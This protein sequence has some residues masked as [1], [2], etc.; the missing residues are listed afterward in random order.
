MS[1]HRVWPTHFI[2]HGDGPWPWLMGSEIHKK[3]LNL[4]QSL[5]TLIPA[6]GEQ[7]RAIIVVSAHWQEPSFTLMTNSQAPIVYDYEG[8]PKHT[9][10][11]E[12]ATPNDP[13]LVKRIATQIINSGIHLKL[14]PDR[15]FDQGAFAPLTVMF[16]NANIPT[17]QISLNTRLDAQEHLRLGRALAPLRAEG[18]LIIGSGMSFHNFNLDADKTLRF[19]A[20]FDDWLQRCLEYAPA[21][22][23]QR[24]CDWRCA[25]SAILA[26]PTPEHFLPLLVALGAAEADIAT[27]TYTENDYIENITL[28]GYRFG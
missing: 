21:E 28:S 6:I 8:F 20:I 3:H 14:E 19:S 2:S 22:R 27:K 16:P 17:F 25:H 4:E 12:Y 10:A 5:R 15:G 11:I 1:K 7:P 24:L 26:H 13:N 23:W 9:Y 18:V